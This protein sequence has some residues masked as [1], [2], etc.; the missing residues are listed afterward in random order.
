M[1][2]TFETPRGFDAL[3]AEWRDL[4][5][6]EGMRI[7]QTY[8]WN[9]LAWDNCVSGREERLFLIRWRSGDARESVIFPFFI[10]GSGCLRFIMDRHSDV[11]NAVYRNE[12]LLPGACGEVADLI[13]SEKRIKSVWLQKMQGGSGALA[14]LSAALHKS[15]VY[16]DNAYPY[17]VPSGK[18]FIAGMQWTKSS[19]RA[20]LKA[21]CRKFPDAGIEYL[22]VANGDAFPRDAI[23]ALRSGM[24]SDGSRKEDF[25]TPE[26][27]AFAESLYNSGGGMSVCILKNNGKPEALNFILEKGNR[28]LSWIFLYADKNASSVLLYTKLMQKLCAENPAGYVFD[29]GVGVY[30]YKI[31]TFRPMLEPLFSLRASKSPWGGLRMLYRANVRLLKDLLKPRLKK[32]K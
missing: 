28:F 16:K 25:L 7:F 30:D 32:A 18:D 6:W 27:L 26:M 24:L 12:S 9:R 1:V 29:F 20:N 11:C 2:E 13:A 5:R 4:E 22:S 3:E 21:A 10:D 31:R 14:G 23:L 8:D 15:F 17:V 19:D